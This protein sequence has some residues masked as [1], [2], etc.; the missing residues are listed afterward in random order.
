MEGGKLVVAYILLDTSWQG[1]WTQVMC[2]IIHPRISVTPQHSR[3]RHSSN[4]FLRFTYVLLPNLM[5]MSFLIKHYINVLCVTKGGTNGGFRFNRTN[6]PNKSHH[7]SDFT[8][9]MTTYITFF[10]ISDNQMNCFGLKL[11]TD[12]ITLSSIFIVITHWQWWL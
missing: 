9:S 7:G 5:H 2:V 11:L 12:L 10:H 1:Y 6:K 8:F 3:L 4:M